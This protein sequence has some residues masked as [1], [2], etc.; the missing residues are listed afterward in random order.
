[1]GL[2]GRISIASLYYYATPVFILLDYFGGV[3]V[4][5]AVLD[6]MPLYKNL[7]YGFCILCGVGVYALPRLTPVVALFERSINF[8]MT[9]LAVF[10]PYIRFITQTDDVL[11]APLP[12]VAGIDA[13][14][15]A[16]ILLAGGIAV[17]GFHGSLRAMGLEGHR[18]TESD[19]FR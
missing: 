16:N 15:I 3:N 10:L 12:T 17:L 5:V 13:P 8:L 6:A 4:R 14:H 19:H 9:V 11:T 7:Y 1:M 2:R 18:E